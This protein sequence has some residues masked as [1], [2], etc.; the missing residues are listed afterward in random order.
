MGIFSSCAASVVRGGVLVLKVK[1]EYASP[2][3][4]LHKEDAI[5]S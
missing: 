2:P 5:R 3:L 1:K 4:M